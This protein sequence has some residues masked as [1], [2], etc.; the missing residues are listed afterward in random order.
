MERA[1]PIPKSVN[2][3]TTHIEDEST[4][5][6]RTEIPLDAEK[7]SD[8]ITTI[9][10]LDQIPRFWMT[11]INESALIRIAIRSII[12]SCQAFRDGTF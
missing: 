2:T 3:V 9:N 6:E 10:A 4:T 11:L 8:V 7:M 5:D 12:V 1:M